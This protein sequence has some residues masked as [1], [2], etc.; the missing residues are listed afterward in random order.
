[1]VIS[2]TVVARELGKIPPDV[3]GK[4]QDLIKSLFS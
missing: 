3:L 4:V 1:M 2:S